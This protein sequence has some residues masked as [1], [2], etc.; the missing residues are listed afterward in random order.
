LSTRAVLPLLAT[1]HE[2]LWIPG[3]GRSEAARVTDKTR[4]VLRIKA[5]PIG[6]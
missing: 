5:V 6:A 3:Y 2:I 1:G 4:S